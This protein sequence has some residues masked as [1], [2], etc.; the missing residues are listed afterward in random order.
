MKCI[1][2]GSNNII[3]HTDDELRG[4]HLL[5]WQCFDCK[6][7]FETGWDVEVDGKLNAGEILVWK[8]LFEEQEGYCARCGRHQA[9]LSGTF[10]LDKDPVF[11]TYTGLLC[12][13]CFWVIAVT[14]N[15][16]TREENYRKFREDFNV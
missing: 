5:Q 14:G 3:A 16:L 6:D 10:H 2:C 1:N 4:R 13:R 15:G 7:Y 12:L 8:H 11:G 9:E